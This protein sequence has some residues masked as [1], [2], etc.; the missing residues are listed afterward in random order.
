MWPKKPHKTCAYL[1]CCE[2]A[3]SEGS[4]VEVDCLQKFAF[5]GKIAK[6]RSEPNIVEQSTESSVWLHKGIALMDFRT[7]LKLILRIF[8]WML[9]YKI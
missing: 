8:T 3:H 4:N 7:Q 2:W 5:S 6:T 1:R 9:F